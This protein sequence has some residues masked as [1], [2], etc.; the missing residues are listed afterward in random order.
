[1]PTTVFLIL[2][3]ACYVRASPRFY[4]RLLSHPTFGPVIA[5]WRTHRAMSRRNKRVAIALVIVT[6]GT[7]I[8]LCPLPAV[9]VLLGSIGLG[10]IVFLLGIT[11]KP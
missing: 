4:N 9:K 11:T 5:D 6:V 10:V 8:L 3:A 1:M 7:S 2:A